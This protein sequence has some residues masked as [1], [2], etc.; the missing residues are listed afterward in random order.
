[1]DDQFVGADTL[2][3]LFVLYRELIDFMEEVKIPL[4]KW[5]SNSPEF[6]E[7]LQ[8][9][10]ETSKSFSLEN[11]VTA[12]GLHWNPTTDCY[13]FSSSLILT[14]E[15]WTKRSILSIIAKLYDPVAWIT[16]VII[17]AKILMQEMWID[18]INWDQELPRNLLDQ[19]LE[20]RGDLSRIDRVSLPRWLGSKKNTK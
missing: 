7:F 14:R 4:D 20:I 13:F 17:R 11:S 18:G 19:W 5:A 1:M 2:E 9:E 15:K 10:V 3:E 6:I 12:L 16:P 8:R